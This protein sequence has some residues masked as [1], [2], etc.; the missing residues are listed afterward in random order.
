MVDEPEDKTFDK[1]EA[2]ARAYTAGKN[3]ERTSE[4]RMG[5]TRQSRPG[6]ER[7]DNPLKAHERHRQ[8]N[9]ADHKAQLQTIADPARRA[10][11]GAQIEK[12]YKSW[13]T[14]LFKAYNQRYDNSHT[15][16]E[17]KLAE[18]KIDQRLIPKDQKEDMRKDAIREAV[19]QS[20]NRVAEINSSLPRII[21]RTLSDAVKSTPEARRTPLDNDTQRA[22]DAAAAVRARALQ[23]GHDRSD[24]DR[25]R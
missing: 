2:E 5:S 15:I 6:V 16:Y 14:A 1:F 19:A 7:G 9:A 24:R 17:R 21:D 22:K 18:S 20:N 25:E 23:R 3:R 8:E 4:T 12:H 13:S 11:I 10:E